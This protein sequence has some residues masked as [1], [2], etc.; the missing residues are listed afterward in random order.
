M[1]ILDIFIHEMGNQSSQRIAMSSIEIP[2]ERLML[3]L[4]GNTDGV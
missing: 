3:S 4:L 1:F 2:Y